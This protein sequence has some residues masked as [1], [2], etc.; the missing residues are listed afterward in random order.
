MAR[1][2]R[3]ATFQDEAAT[4]WDGMDEIFVT[5]MELLVAAAP[6]AACWYCFN[7]CLMVQLR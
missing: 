3:Q 6:I 5:P 2:C 1:L 7:S 4:L